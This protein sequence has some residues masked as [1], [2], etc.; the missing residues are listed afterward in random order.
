M[1]SLRGRISYR[2][3]RSIVRGWPEDDS[4]TLV[5]RARR[6]FGRPLS[7]GP[8]LTRGIKIQPVTGEVKGEWLAPDRLGFSDSVLLYLHGG[9]YVSCSARSH[10]PITSTLARQIGCRVFSLDYRLAPEYPFP[11][12]VDD[13]ANAYQWLLKSGIKAQNIALAGDSAGGGL[14]IATMLRLRDEKIP[15]PACAACIAPWV[16]LLEEFTPTNTDSCAMFLPAD[17]RS[18][19]KVYLNGASAHAPLASPLFG[20]LHGLPPLLI[21]VADTEMLFDDAFRLNEKAQAAG[22]QSKLHIYKGLPHVWHM[23]VGLVPE[24]G[25]AL[26]EIADFIREKISV[27][28]DAVRGEGAPAAARP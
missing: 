15:L 26:T 13:A 5:R 2:L 10:R 23:F 1:P 6:I 22:V 4:A 19:A 21:Q 24:A 17:G 28:R 12:A 3:V 11:A 18:F 27:S 14:A 7:L 9:G 20:D 16:D 8:W 25:Q